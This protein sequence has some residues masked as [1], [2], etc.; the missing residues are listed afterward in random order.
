MERY[1]PSLDFGFVCNFDICGRFEGPKSPTR[2]DPACAP[3]PQSAA[4]PTSGEVR[5]IVA[6]EGVVGELISYTTQLGMRVPE[7]VY[8]PAGRRT[9][10]RPALLIVNGHGGDQYSW[11]AF[12]AGIA[13]A[14]AALVLT[15]DPLGEGER[16]VIK[17][18]VEATRESL[19]I[20]QA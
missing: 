17:E 4:Q 9:E 14:R 3:C 10:N 18:V 13:Y 5:R 8:R 20:G 15:Y 19:V 1:E 16:S 6:S 7:I 12:Y 11:C 2:G